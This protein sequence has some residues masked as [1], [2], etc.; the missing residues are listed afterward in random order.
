MFTLTTI[1]STVRLGGRIGR[2]VRLLV[3]FEKD[4]ESA[5]L[6]AVPTPSSIVRYLVRR[7]SWIAGFLLLV[8]LSVQLA[9][10]AYACSAGM[11]TDTPRQEVMGAMEDMA[12]C[13]EMAGMIDEDAGHFNGEKAFCMGHCQA[14][15]KHADQPAPQVFAFIPVL[16][17]VIVEPPALVPAPF[18]MQRAN[19][20][21]RAPP[22]P[23]A[24]L[25]C[26]L[27]T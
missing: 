26:C 9:A 20:Q 27:R 24:I 22:P 10:A 5:I 25:H 8:F 18:F 21:P 15:T 6:T 19:A 14:D 12:S 16:V 4:I 17:G 1:P 23:H 3:A 2:R 11:R 13:A 7:H